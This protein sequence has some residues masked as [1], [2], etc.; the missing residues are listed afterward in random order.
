MLPPFVA[1]ARFHVV[2]ELVF[3]EMPDDSV[4]EG[5]VLGMKSCSSAISDENLRRLQAQS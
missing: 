2:W 4:V 5:I 1:E 3:Q